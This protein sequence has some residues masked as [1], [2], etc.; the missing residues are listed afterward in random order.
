MVSTLL[1]LKT[2][3]IYIDLNVFL[4]F[5][6]DRGKVFLLKIRSST[7]VSLASLQTTSLSAVW[8]P[9]KE[10]MIDWKM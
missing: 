5:I 10:E 9:E 3:R 7:N 2:S 4:I 8:G 6:Y 1:P